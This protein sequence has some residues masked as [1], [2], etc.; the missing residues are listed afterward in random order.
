[1]DG[2]DTGFRCVDLAFADGL[3]RSKN[4]A[5]DIGQAHPVVVDQVERAHTGARQRLYGIAA[6]AADAED[7]NTASGKDLHCLAAE[8]QLGSGKLIEHG[9]PPHRTAEMV[10]GTPSRPH[11]KTV[12][13]ARR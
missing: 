10:P 3:A 4:L 8:H 7:G 13:A 1:M 11:R 2:A 12:Q 5:V 9:R 6:D